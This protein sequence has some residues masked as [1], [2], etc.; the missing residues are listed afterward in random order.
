MLVTWMFF[1]SQVRA[2]E[3]CA[4]HSAVAPAHRRA[5]RFRLTCSLCFP[6]VEPGELASQ[7]DRSYLFETV[8]PMALTGEQ[9]TRGAVGAFGAEDSCSLSM[10]QPEDR[11][12]SC[13]TSCA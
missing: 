1:G 11:S 4:G 8:A 5:E 7:G 13:C 2:V 10:L 12:P 9:K 3:S 6:A